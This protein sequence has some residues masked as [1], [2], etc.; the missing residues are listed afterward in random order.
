MEETKDVRSKARSTA[1]TARGQEIRI[2]LAELWLLPAP[3]VN[4]IDGFAADS[5]FLAIGGT[6]SK[7]CTVERFSTDRNEWASCADFPSG[8]QFGSACNVPGFGFFVISADPSSGLSRPSA[9]LYNSIRD[10]WIALAPPVRRR[11]RPAC[12][13]HEDSVYVVSGGGELDAASQRFSLRSDKWSLLPTVP[14]ALYNHSATVVRSAGRGVPHVLVCSESGQRTHAFNI[15]T[16]SWED[17]SLVPP[18]PRAQQGVQVASC[19]HTGA[20]CLACHCRLCCRQLR[21]CA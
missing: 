18:L 11:Y 7:H 19:Q 6:E 10:K 12:V 1:I 17:E 15:E 21:S 5:C 3:V 4:I 9:H 14:E 8:F 16:Q 20:S 2:V 13:A